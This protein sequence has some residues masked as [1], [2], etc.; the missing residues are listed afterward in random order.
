VHDLVARLAGE[1][2]CAERRV[3][4]AGVAPRVKASAVTQA[5]IDVERRLFLAAVAER[6][7]VAELPAA[8]E[9]VAIEHQPGLT[10]RHPALR[11][12]LGPGERNQRGRAVVL[13]PNPKWR[14]PV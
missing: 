6:G 13:V 8:G 7:C 11:H 5:A 14:E 2:R 9:C 4:L 10:E 12:E 3:H 1:E